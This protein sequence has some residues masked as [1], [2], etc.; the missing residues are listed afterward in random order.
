MW[1]RRK[2][3]N[4]QRAMKERKCFGCGGFRH[5]ACHCR[6]IGEKGSV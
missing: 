1:E 3:K 4:K 6:N 2:E 5:I